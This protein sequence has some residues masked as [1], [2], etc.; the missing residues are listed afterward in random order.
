MPS[1]LP[2][3]AVLVAKAGRA[4]GVRGEI[5]L[6]PESGDP[7]R[8]LGLTKAWI[9]LPGEP[10]RMLR[11]AARRAHQGV[12]LVRFDGIGSPEDVAR[13]THGEVWALA[14]E[15]PERAGDEFSVDEV[16]GMRLFDGDVPVGDIAA[17]SSGGGRDFFEVDVA[18]KRELIPAVKDWLVEFDRPGR[19][20][21]MRLPAG[22]LGA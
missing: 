4:H 19:R 3:D 6:I 18:G 2:E 20:I 8:I 12:A 22:L 17:V 11:I 13:L 16:I 15:L 14:S 10:A 9:V 1:G 21:V 5:R 7:G